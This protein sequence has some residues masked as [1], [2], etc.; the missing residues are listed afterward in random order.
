MANSRKIPMLVVGKLSQEQFVT[1]LGGVFEH[2]PW[3]AAEAW[4]E[5]PFRTREKLHGAMMDVARRSEPEALLAL[6][7]GHPDLATRLQ[8]TEYSAR[9]QQGAGLDRLTEA[10]YETFLSCNRAYT[11]KFGFPFIM[12]VRG[13]NKD[14][15]LAAMKARIGND[16]ATERETA[17][18]EIGAIT[19]FRLADLLEP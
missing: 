19:G 12:A 13:R 5:R 11:D 9:E 16:E 15:I 18:S 17:L 8:V 4:H 7:R 10:E 6:L 3:I 2:A 14:E 1:V